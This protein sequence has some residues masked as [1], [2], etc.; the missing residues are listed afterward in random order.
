MIVSLSSSPVGSEVSPVI[1][2]IP[3]GS[4]SSQREKR[5]NRQSGTKIVR[6]QLW[7]SHVLQ[8][9]WGYLDPH[10]LTAFD[11]N[12]FRLAATKPLYKS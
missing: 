12:K 2:T 6:A 1:D 8:C 11:G 4:A 7:S 3:T 5:S 9:N 10:L